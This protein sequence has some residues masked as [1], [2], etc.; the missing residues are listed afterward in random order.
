MKIYTVEEQ[1]REQFFNMNGNPWKI[2]NKMREIA[3]IAE[4]KQMILRQ[5]M[6]KQF[7]TGELPMDSDTFKLPIDI[8]NE[9]NKQER[10]PPAI[11]LEHEDADIEMAD[12][13]DDKIE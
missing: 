10:L 7:Q 8:I 4:A 3:K 13:Q 2:E 1:F 12:L 5:F 6:W 11:D 9:Q